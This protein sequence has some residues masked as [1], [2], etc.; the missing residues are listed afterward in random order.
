MVLIGVLCVLAF[1]GLGA[2]GLYAMV[3]AMLNSGRGWL[4]KPMDQTSTA[5]FGGA[6]IWLMLAMVAFWL[7]VAVGHVA[8]RWGGIG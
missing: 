8:Q 2:F 7:M 4:R 3:R 1:V 5:D 6:L